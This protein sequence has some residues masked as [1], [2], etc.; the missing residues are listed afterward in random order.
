MRF[1]MMILAAAWAVGC[2]TAKPEAVSFR[3]DIAPLLRAKCQACHGER[4]AEGDFRVDSFTELMRT[5]ADEPARVLAGQPEASLLLEL[6]VT[7]D[8]DEQMPQK[9]EPLEANEVALFR[10][11]IAEGAKF[12][13]ADPALSL[14]QVI[15]AREHAAAPVKYPRALPVTAL[16]FS[17]DG[18]ELAVSG[19]R[20]V[21]V[22]NPATGQLLRRI[23]GMAQRTYALAWSP[24]GGTLAAGGGIPGELGEVRVFNAATG[25]L[26]AVAH[27]AGDV[28]L[29]VQYDANGTQLAVADADNLITVY[30]ADDFSTRLRIDNHSGWVMAL[31]FSPD[32]R[33]L[34]SASRDRSAKIFEIKTGEPISTYGGHGAPVLGVAFRA[35]GKQMF[36]S[37][38]GGKIHVWKSGL[39]DIDGKRFGAEKVAEIS[40]LG[41]EVYKLVLHGNL[42]FSVSAD[43]KA[44]VHQATDRRLVREFSVA[45]GSDWLQS[46][47]FHAPSERLATGVHDGTVRVWDTNTGK[48]LKS[49]TATPR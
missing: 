46:L 41:R 29:D 23:P 30:H 20:E 22:W 25:N 14:A 26:K 44:R 13:G 35:D 27:K 39:A 8:A 15:P 6:L 49:F 2:T 42:V 3:A 12:D 48:L 38:R 1:L 17:P 16:A 40:G 34:A 28:V 37:G 19:L 18:T 5:V 45:D 4:K 47:A 31:A 9:S 32:L 24:N 43:G 10:K 36:S 11:W 7:E 33:F 21:T